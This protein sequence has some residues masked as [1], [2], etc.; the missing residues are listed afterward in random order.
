MHESLFGDEE[1]EPNPPAPH[2]ILAI[3]NFALVFYVDEISNTRFLNQCAIVVLVM[4]RTWKRKHDKED[5]AP[6]LLVNKS[7]GNKIVMANKGAVTV[8]GE[9]LLLGTTLKKNYG[10][11]T[12]EGIVTSFKAPYYLVEY[13]DGDCEELTREEVF[14]YA[15]DLLVGA[16]FVKRFG[17]SSYK[18]TV[19]NFK[20]PYYLVDYEDG[21]SEELTRQEVLSYLQKSP[22]GGQLDINIFDPIIGRVVRKCFGAKVFLGA[23]IEYSLPYYRVQ[24]E[25]T[26]VE[27]SPFFFFFV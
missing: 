9:D 22:V 19:V 16:T 17:L 8:E 12:Y 1:G 13:E 7:K 21:D 5:A 24:Y 11:K 6:G 4:Q 20:A 14:S 18:G 25:D 15:T 3:I 26:D 27:V 2:S 10:N 23:V